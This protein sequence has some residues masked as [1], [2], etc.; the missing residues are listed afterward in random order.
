MNNSKSFVL[1]LIIIVLG[2][3]AFFYFR[4]VQT[5]IT[6]DFEE[7]SV[8]RSE[9]E[10]NAFVEYK[11]QEQLKPSG[12]NGISEMQIL[13]H[14]NL[15]KGYVTQVNTLNKELE[16]LVKEGKSDS[17]AFADRRRRYGFEYN[18]MVLHEY[19]FGNL[20]SQTTTLDP[21]GLKQEL[22]KTWGSYDL[23][24]ADFVNTGK[25][26]GIGWAI[27][28]IDPTTG[29][30]SNIFVVDHQDGN[31][32]GFVPLLVMDVWEHAYMVDH[33][34]GGRADYIKAFV[35][36]INW[37]VVEKRFADAMAG[38]ITKRF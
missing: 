4:K 13:D 25:T 28:Y 35:Q 29:Q 1:L 38:K 24:L 26:R 11:V 20:T 31:I 34:S 2:I 15:Y 5:N 21:K 17:L 7:K 27:L 33:K 14:W 36:N 23:W 19:Y 12:L 8:N 22:E 18:G 10:M 3:I 16:S 6:Q 32:A 9:I 37:Q 30:L